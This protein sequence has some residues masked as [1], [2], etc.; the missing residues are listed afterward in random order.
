MLRFLLPASAVE[1]LCPVVP[2]DSDVSAAKHLQKE[3]SEL[4]ELNKTQTN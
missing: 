1:R 2:C 3:L 4:L